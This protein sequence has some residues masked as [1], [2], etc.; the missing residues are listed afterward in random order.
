M[1]KSVCLIILSNKCFLVDLP[2]FSLIAVLPKSKIVLTVLFITTLYINPPA[3][4]SG[5]HP[6]KINKNVNVL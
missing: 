4:I 5:K 2:V 6:F 1:S 3:L